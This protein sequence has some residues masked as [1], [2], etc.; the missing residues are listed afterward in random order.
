MVKLF[1]NIHVSKYEV[2]H[3]RLHTAQYGTRISKENHR[4]GASDK[5][6]R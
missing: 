2:D 3:A 6:V 1:Y 4:A 5:K